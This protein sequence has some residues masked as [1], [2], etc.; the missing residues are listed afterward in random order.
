MAVAN[1]T[2]AGSVH[3]GLNYVY[4]AKSVGYTEYSSV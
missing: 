2:N 3:T 4:F 1:L